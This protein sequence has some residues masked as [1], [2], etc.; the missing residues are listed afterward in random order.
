MKK[1]YIV[2]VLF[3]FLVTLELSIP[4]SVYSISMGFING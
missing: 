3:L 4:N 2:G 1:V